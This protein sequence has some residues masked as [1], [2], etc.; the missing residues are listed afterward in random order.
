ML[1]NLQTN[2]LSW[3]YEKGTAVGQSANLKSEMLQEAL[4]TQDSSKGHLGEFNQ[5]C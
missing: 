2:I 3:T 5:H 1:D 4:F